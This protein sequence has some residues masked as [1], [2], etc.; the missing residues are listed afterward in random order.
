[1]FLLLALAASLALAFAP[2]LMPPA[3]VPAGAPATAFSDER[4]MARVRVV[5]AEPHPFGS[6]QH[7][8]AVVYLV[9]QLRDL[10]VP[11]GAFAGIMAAAFDTRLDWPTVLAG[12]AAKR[13]ADAL[14]QKGELVAS[15]DSFL[16]TG[17]NE[18][19]LRD[20]EL[21]RAGAWAGTVVGNLAGAATTVSAH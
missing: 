8:V 4:A 19:H 10:G 5:A 20:G 21:A 6:P 12:S 17:L 7:D 14:R 2:L 3:V 11:S 13:I 1:V 16:G 9:E 18:F 15:P